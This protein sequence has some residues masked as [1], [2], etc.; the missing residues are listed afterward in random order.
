MK[1]K[2]WGM[3]SKGITFWFICLSSYTWMLLV[4]SFSSHLLLLS[5]RLLRHWE[6]QPGECAAGFWLPGTRSVQTPVPE[7]LRVSPEH[8]AVCSPSYSEKQCS[9]FYS[10]PYRLRGKG[11]PLPP[12]EKFLGPLSP[13]LATGSELSRTRRVLAAASCLS[14]AG[15]HQL[16]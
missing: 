4:K 3:H 13:C 15:P 12:L 16:L 6:G 10:E 7:S 1:L 2:Q 5:L 14:L 9:S 8:Q 11:L